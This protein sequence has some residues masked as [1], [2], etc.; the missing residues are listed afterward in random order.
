MLQVRLLGRC[1]YGALLFDAAACFCARRARTGIPDAIPGLLAPALVRDVFI[2]G[3]LR[4]EARGQDHRPKIATLMAGIAGFPP[5]MW[6]HGAG[7]DV[8]KRIAAPMIGGVVT[9]FHLELIVYSVN[10]EVWR[11]WEM[12]RLFQRV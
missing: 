6:S 4:V 3:V 10:F 5:I 8:M 12:R 9:S 2:T 7:A 11:G 1:D